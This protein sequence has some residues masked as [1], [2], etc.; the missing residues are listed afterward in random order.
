MS[1]VYQRDKRVKITYAYESHSYW[2]KSKKQ[3]RAHRKLIGKVDD[4]TGE[5]V[6]TRKKK[7]PQQI[8]SN[9]KYAGAS[10]LFDQIVK[11]IGLFDNLKMCFAKEYKKILSIA[12]YLILEDKN[13][14]SRFSKWSKTHMHPY[15][16]DMCE[17]QML[18]THTK[19]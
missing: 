3:S 14:L 4:K 18:A 5:I 1:I 15:K 13:A 17:S 10:Y 11:K 6:P 16:K 8:F 12:Y 19:T 7:Q 9:R 2:D